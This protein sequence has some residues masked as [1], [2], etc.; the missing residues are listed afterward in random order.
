MFQKDFVDEAYDDRPTVDNMMSS[1]E[2]KGLIIK[3][4]DSVDKRKYRILNMQI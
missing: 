3:E 2:K 4:T 1:L